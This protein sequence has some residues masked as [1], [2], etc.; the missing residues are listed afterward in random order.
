QFMLAISVGQIML[1]VAEFGL[2]QHLATLLARKKHYPSTILMQVTLVKSVLL[3]L[4]WLGMLIFIFWQG[5]T[6]EMKM[7]VIII[8]TGV[9]LEALASSFYVACQVL[10]RQD[11]EGRWRS[12]AA[13]AGFG[14]GIAALL[15]GLSSFFVAFFRL[16][17]TTIAIS[18]AGMSIL[19]RARARVKPE[20]L[21][22]I[23]K[24]WRGGLVYTLMAI[25]AIFYNK[26]NLFYLQKYGGAMGVAQYSVTWQI[27][28]GVS[29]MVSGMLLRRVLFPLFVK[30]WVSNREEFYGLARNTSRWL[31]ATSLPVMFLLG[32]ESDRIIPAIFGDGYADAVWMQH[33]LVGC[34]LFAFIHNLAHYL[35][36]SIQRE[37]LLLIF[38]VL[39]LIFNVICCAVLIPKYPLWGTALSIV[40][41]KG[42]VA[43]MTVTFCQF[44]LRM[45]P[46]AGLFHI[47][48]AV[49]AGALLY[50]A[51]IK[52]LF[53]EAGELLALAPMI[54]LAWQWK[55]SLNRTTEQML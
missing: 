5:Y 28:D 55:R 14:Y 15:G 45:I 11:V 37:R 6:P 48:L 47:F 12:L 18:G 51:G 2:N 42:F 34:I 3:G 30:L 53:R 4:S 21:R 52:Y 33:Y 1:F 46:M 41:T 27:V 13:F 32:V 17:E 10:D 8:S 44:R 54:F 50:V 38:Y 25:A 24:T 29:I 20:Q 7:L 16:V 26:I 9:G 19:R 35:M 22:L 31:I 43:L 40:M 49:A 39:G 36:I 23:W